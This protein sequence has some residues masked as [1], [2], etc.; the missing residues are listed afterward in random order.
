MGVEWGK[1]LVSALPKRI[2]G[3]GNVMEWGKA[4]LNVFSC[5]QAVRCDKFN[6]I[7][8]QR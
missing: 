1:T 5:S 3:S 4:I 8:R 6:P 2:V 7:A